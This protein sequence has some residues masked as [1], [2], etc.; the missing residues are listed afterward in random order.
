MQMVSA[1]AALNLIEFAQSSLTVIQ[2]PC[3]EKLYEELDNK[4]IQRLSV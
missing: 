2:F 4:D 3:S 1:P